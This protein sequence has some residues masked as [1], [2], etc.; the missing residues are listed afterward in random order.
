MLED[1]LKAAIRSGSVLIGTRSV[2]RALRTGGVESVIMSSNCPDSTRKD[3]EQYAKLSGTKLQSFPG[4]G[5]Q[6]GVLCGKPFSI[7]T[8]AISKKAK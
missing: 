5:S 6:L 4:T 8:L 7:A 1:E 2:E 3:V